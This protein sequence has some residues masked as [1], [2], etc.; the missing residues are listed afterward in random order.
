M[1]ACGV[2]LF[3]TLHWNTKCCEVL[4]IEIEVTD[5]CVSTE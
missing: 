1:L 2:L 5:C 3:Y 4:R